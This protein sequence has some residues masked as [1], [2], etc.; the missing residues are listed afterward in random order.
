M[1]AAKPQGFPWASLGGALK[2]TTAMPTWGLPWDIAAGL[3]KQT[4]ANAT[5]MFK[6][7][8]GGLPLGKLERNLGCSLSKPQ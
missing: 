7:S 4:K 6:P 2:Q 1:G 8:L 3:P 5:G